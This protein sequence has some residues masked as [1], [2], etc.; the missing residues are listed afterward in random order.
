MKA[1][2]LLLVP[3]LSPLLAVLLVAA[4]NPGPPLSVRLLTWVSP[5]VAVRLAGATVWV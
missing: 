3:F 2:R 4:F 5:G 1:Q